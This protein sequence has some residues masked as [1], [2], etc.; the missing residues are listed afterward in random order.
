MKKLL[1]MIMLL[2][3]IN[4]FAQAQT[5]VHKTPQQKAQHFTKVLQKKLALSADQ[6]AKVNTILLKRATQ[7]DSLKANKA[8]GDRKLNKMAR[9]K[10][11][12]GADAEVKAVLTADQ[13]KTYADLKAGMK[14]KMKARR[15]AKAPVAG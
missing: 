11:L 14:E 4:M 8:T 1:L 13:Q 2:A 15:A 5:K 6:S 7:M 12:S 9:R 3:G 10:I